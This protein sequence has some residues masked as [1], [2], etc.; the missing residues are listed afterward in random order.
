MG[1]FSVKILGGRK[2]IVHKLSSTSIEFKFSSVHRSPASMQSS[3]KPK[4]TRKVVVVGAGPVGCLAALSFAKMGW[5][6]EVYEGRPGM[7]LYILLP[8]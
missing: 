3:E 1:A 4:Q 5:H 2:V 7:S 8:L 6:V